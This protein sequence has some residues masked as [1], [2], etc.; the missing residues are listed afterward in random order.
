VYG[1]S[2]LSGGGRHGG[3][4]RRGEMGRIGGVSTERKYETGRGRYVSK[5]AEGMWTIWCEMNKGR[6][7]KVEGVSIRRSGETVW[8]AGGVE[9]TVV[10]TASRPSGE[11]D[12]Q[13]RDGE[14]AWA[15]AG[16]ANGTGRT[17]DGNGGVE[18]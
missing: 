5:A 15:L 10:S 1:K 7:V 4:A 6:E 3:C 2:N 9:R 11:E 14:C 12:R 18:T 8:I 13:G 16:T 17:V